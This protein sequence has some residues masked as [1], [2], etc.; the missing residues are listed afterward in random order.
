MSTLHVLCLIFVTNDME[1]I[2][3]VLDFK[4]AFDISF[5]VGMYTPGS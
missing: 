4:F 1:F 5:Y 2:W 3:H